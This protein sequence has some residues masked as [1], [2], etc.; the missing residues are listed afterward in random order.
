MSLVAL[1]MVN[2]K[3]GFGQSTLIN[4]GVPV[5]MLSG[6]SLFIS[7]DLVNEDDGAYGNFSASLGGKIGV[8]GSVLNNADTVLFGSGDSTSLIILNGDSHKISGTGGMN[9]YTLNLSTGGDSI[10]LERNLSISDSLNFNSGKLFLNGKVI[11]LSTQASL[12]GESETSRAYGDAGTIKTQRALSNIN[13]NVANLGLGINSS[14]NLGMTTITRGHGE[15]TA[16]DTSMLRYISFDPTFNGSLN[17]SATLH[18]FDAEL[19][20]LNESNIQL[21]RS[22]DN[23][24]T[25]QIKLSSQNSSA[26]TMYHQGLDSLG[27]FT[28]AND[29]CFGNE[30]QVDLG[31]DTSICSGDSLLLDASGPGIVGFIWNTGAS[32]ASIAIASADTYVVTITDTTGCQGIDSILV[33]TV[34]V[35]FTDLGSDSSICSGDSIVLNGTDQNGTNPSYLWSTSGANALETIG[36]SVAMIDSVWVEL[37]NGI[38]SF[39]DSIIV[40]VILTPSI[41]LGNDTG[42]CQLDSLTLDAGNAGST[43][44][45][46]TADTT[47]TISVNATSSYVVTATASG[48]CSSSD[49]I[50]VIK[51]N[52]SVN[53]TGYDAHCF[54]YIDG[55]AV[56][57]ALNGISPIAYDWSNGDTSS[58]AS[59]LDTGVYSVL[60]TDSLAC[61]AHDTVSI[62]QPDSLVLSF[63]VTN[64]ACQTGGGGSIDMTITGGTSPYSI[65]WNYFQSTSEDLTGLDSG[66]YSVFVMDNNQCATMATVLVTQ[67]ESFSLSKSFSDISCNNANDASISYSV[68]GGL[69][70]FDFAWSIS[71]SDSIQ[72]NLSSGTYYVT[73]TDSNNCVESDTTVVTNPTAISLSLSDTNIS[74]FEYSNGSILATAS[75]G[76]GTLSIQ[77]NTGDTSNYISNLDTG[78]YVVTV[79]DDNNCQRQDSS[80]LSQPQLLAHSSIISNISCY[81]LSSGSIDI[82][83]SGGTSPYSYNWSNGATTQDISNVGAGTYSLIITDNKGC[84]SLDTLV[85][86]QPD[87]LVIASDSITHPLCNGLNSGQITISVAGGTTPYSYQWSNASTN[88]NLLSAVAGNYSVTITDSNNCQVNASYTLTQPTAIDL[89]TSTTQAQC[90][91]A[92]GTASVS[93]SGGVSPYVIL[94][95]STG[96]SQAIDSFLVAGVYPVHVTD[97]N[98]CVDSAFAAISN[99]SSPTISLDSINSVDCYGHQNGFIALSI[100]GGTFPYTFSWNNGETVEDI[101]TLSGGTYNFT[102]T[103]DSNC[104]ATQ[105]FIISEPDSLTIAHITQQVTC[106]GLENGQVNLIV[107]GGSAPY[108]YSWSNGS[109]NDSLINVGQDTYFL[110]LTDSNSCV[111]F[112]SVTIT[113]PDS[114]AISLLDTNISCFGF[115]D[116]RIDAQVIGGTSG[117]SYSWSNGEINQD[118]SGLSAGIYTLVVTDANGCIKNDSAF[119]SEPL[120]LSSSSIITHLLCN[121]DSLG[122]IE[123]SVSGGVMPYD[124]LWS[125]GDTAAALSGLMGGTYNVTVL[126]SNGCSLLDTSS[127][128][129]PDALI[130]NLTAADYTCPTNINGA[131]TTTLTGGTNPY[132]YLWHTGDTTNAI[133]GLMGGT[134][135][136]T[137]TDSNGCSMND[138]A[139]V[140]GNNEM[141][142]SLAVQHISCSSEND[143]AIDLTVVGGISPYGYLWS[144]A[145]INQ[146]LSNLGEGSY[147]VTVTDNVNCVMIADTNISMPSA[148]SI[149]DSVGQPQCSGSSNG[150]IWTS[151]VGGTGD[152]SFNWSNGSTSDSLNTLAGGTYLLTV[153]DANGCTSSA[154]YSLI[155]PLSIVLNGSAK[156][157]GCGDDPDNGGVTLV[158]SG[159]TSPYT[160]SWNSGSTSQNLEGVSAG[161]YSVTLTDANSCI[162]TG[163]FTVGLNGNPVFAKYLSASI[164]TSNDTVRFVNLSSPSSYRWDFDDETTS[165]DS[166][167]LHRFISRID[168]DGDSSYYYVT[169]TASNST[170]TDSLTKLIRVQNLGDGKNFDG[171]A[172]DEESPSILTKAILLEM[173]IYPVPTRSVL[174]YGFEL[175]RKEESL[176]YIANLNGQVIQTLRFPKA[177]KVNGQ[178]DLSHLAAGNYFLTI[179]TADDR[180]TMQFVKL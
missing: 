65:S 91:I 17:A 101:D 85:I 42:L 51:S 172:Q 133:T 14:Q 140:N 79:T 176:L 170:C 40:T 135:T 121:N 29:L 178:V 88:Q 92:D 157:I 80:Y 24:A 89:S 10:L 63:V 147:S 12:Y 130:L 166:S 123:I 136:L 73:V 19:N 105:S 59:Y 43:F 99:P 164:A 93:I 112:D 96:G 120:P 75:G 146:D 6:S 44:L 161:T 103:D 35:P 20:G 125:N 87:E 122:A 180:R 165:E 143:G 144:T 116:G 148:I 64:A 41:H 7:G 83:V 158:P 74:C 60:V 50:N 82:S 76:T 90:G 154:L 109:F 126:D 52:L 25:W 69:S 177:K 151:A 45:W 27:R 28:L 114:I 115:D 21:Y 15:Q 47:Q 171:L 84:I 77:W 23:G 142:I 16:A 55:S 152:L 26:N 129:E 102:V 37:T 71:G 81:G 34:M 149:T 124:Y 98:G 86:S 169:L 94:W 13:L 58:T 46:S 150:F 49:T 97:F 30:P 141:N 175:S 119:I 155:N 127:I 117:Y 174:N 18:Y 33:Q 168:I 57:L 22:T 162:S 2:T 54:G 48:L 106:F 159:G 163:S 9:I 3:C 104:S 4:K 107:A 156:N 132:S 61:T 128:E 70:P 11:T 139:F 173:E 78:W 1:L 100:S 110:T 56:A 179:E 138:S 153:S 167:P 67:P 137:I 32:S 72:T 145:Q 68:V 131:V 95:D 111:Y 62:G 31:N 66:S 113:Q 118:V 108:N 38:C 8:G 5:T 39:R 53:A 160:F 134:Y 36:Y